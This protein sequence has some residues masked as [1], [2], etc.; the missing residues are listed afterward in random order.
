MLPELY[1]CGFCFESCRGVIV[2]VSPTRYIAH[3]KQNHKVPYYHEYN[4]HFLKEYYKAEG[5]IFPIYAVQS[6]IIKVPNLDLVE[7]GLE[8]LEKVER[9]FLEEEFRC[10]K[11]KQT[12]RTKGNFLECHER[13][14]S[15]KEQGR[16]F[17][18]AECAVILSGDNRRIVI[19]TNL[20]FISEAYQK[21]IVP[22]ICGC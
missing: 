20:V 16:H 18:S 12:F 9:K 6:P 10:G 13:G 11:C 17:G 14:L 8:L 7:E 22:G 4:S 1:I 19:P 3:M 15:K 5:Q 21:K 2:F